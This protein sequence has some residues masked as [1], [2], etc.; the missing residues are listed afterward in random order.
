MFLERLETERLSLVRFGH[1]TVDLR[2]LYRTLPAEGMERVARFMPWEP[3]TT[4][5]EIYEFVERAERRWEDHDRA[6]YAIRPHEGEPDG[7]R[8]RATPRSR[9][10]GATA[11][12]SSASGCASPSGDGATRA[13]AHGR[14]WNSRST[15]WISS[16]SP[17]TS[18]TRT[19]AGRSSATST[20]SA[21]SATAC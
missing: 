9:S 13:S 8:T 15:I 3:H 16:R 2:E 21:D 10:T 20:G 4:I 11:P 5:Q 17:T 19:P 18:T 7:A 12:A 6:T 14:C 1:D